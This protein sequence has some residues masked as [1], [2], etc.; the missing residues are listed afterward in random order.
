MDRD[1]KSILDIWA[2]SYAAP[3]TVEDL[4]E[5]RDNVV[6]FFKVLEKWQRLDVAPAM[7]AAPLGPS[8]TDN[9]GGE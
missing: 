4:R 7:P 3:L 1:L 5:I 6:G 8:P 2:G 9:T